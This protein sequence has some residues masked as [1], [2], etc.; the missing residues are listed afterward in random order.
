MDMAGLESLLDAFQAE[1]AAEIEACTGLSVGIPWRLPAD[2][3]RTYEVDMM[4]D[5]EA[6]A[7]AAEAK[8]G[9]ALRQALGPEVAVVFGTWDQ[10]G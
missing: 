1:H 2:H 4:C 7:D 6:Q 9:A 8:I 3:P 5:T 10:A